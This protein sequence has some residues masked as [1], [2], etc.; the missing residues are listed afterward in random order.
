MIS[1][2]RLAPMRRDR[3]WTSSGRTV[4]IS[5]R[6]GMEVMSLLYLRG[7]ETG[8]GRGQRVSFS[9]WDLLRSYFSISM[10]T[11]PFQEA[12]WSARSAMANASWEETRHGGL[13]ARLHRRGSPED[14]AQACSPA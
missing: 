5:M 10:C 8:G 3:L 9:M 4:R 7:A 14:A 6:N 1:V 12:I 13:S 11:L 2:R